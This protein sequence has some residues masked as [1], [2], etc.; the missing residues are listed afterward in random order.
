MLLINKTAFACL[1]SLLWNI[2]IFLP[3]GQFPAA[4]AASLPFLGGVNL[5]GYQLVTSI[6]GVFNGT[7]GGKGS[8]PP[9][10]QIA[11]FA[12]QGVNVFRIRKYI[13]LL[14]VVETRLT[15]IACQHSP[16]N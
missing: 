5:A 2:V 12:N 13:I 15:L 7:N 9:V 11:H 1:A 4:H 6:E 14:E 3:L 8:T 10:G 16:G